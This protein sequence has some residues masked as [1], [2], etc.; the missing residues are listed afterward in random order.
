MDRVRLNVCACT[1][2][3]MFST[4]HIACEYGVAKHTSWWE[5]CTVCK[6][7]I[8]VDILVSALH[9]QKS[10]GAAL[11]TYWWKSTQ[12]ISVL[13]TWTKYDTLI[14][15]CYVQDVLVQ[16]KKVTFQSFIMYVNVVLFALYSNRRTVNLI[17]ISF[18]LR[19]NWL[20]RWSM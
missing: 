5:G 6:S 3:F 17:V 8:I 4:S 20:M 12:V 13:A 1:W 11:K 19:L 9:R 2:V 14:H 10:N 18:G 15:F 7:K 16:E